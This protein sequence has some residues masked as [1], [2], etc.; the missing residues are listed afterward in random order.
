MEPNGLMS[1][2]RRLRS[3]STTKIEEI[4]PQ[5]LTMDHL[6]LGFL[7]CCIP[8]V[9]AISEFAWSRIVTVFGKNSN[10]LRKSN[11]KT[12]SSA[13]ICPTEFRRTQLREK[14]V[15]LEELIEMHC[16]TVA[17]IHQKV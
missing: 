13:K 10:D 14:H 9:L 4:G 12:N 8:M 5:V 2:W 3:F 11:Q 1:H 6:K 16:I 15:K 17:E 7:A